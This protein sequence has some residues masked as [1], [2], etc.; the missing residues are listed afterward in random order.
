MLAFQP[1]SAFEEGPPCWPSI[2]RAWHSRWLGD[3]CGGGES[4]QFLGLGLISTPIFIFQVVMEKEGKWLPY[5]SPHLLQMQKETHTPFI[6]Q[7]QAND[8]KLKTD[9]T[10]I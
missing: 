3:V 7:L 4:V 8:Y 5:A 9:W 1:S 10:Q 6:I 2:L